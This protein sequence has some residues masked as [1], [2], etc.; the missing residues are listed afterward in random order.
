MK[1]TDQPHPRSACDQPHSVIQ[2][3]KNTMF[4]PTLGDFDWLLSELPGEF[5]GVFICH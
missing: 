5:I 4:P 1:S 3:W 2:Q